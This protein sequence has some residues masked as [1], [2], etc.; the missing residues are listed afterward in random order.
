MKGFRNSL[1]LTGE[2]PLPPEVRISDRFRG[3]FTEINPPKEIN[4]STLHKPVPYKWQVLKILSLSNEATS[5]QIYNKMS[6]IDTHPDIQYVSVCM[7]L[8]LSKGLAVRTDNRRLR[9][10]TYTI[11]KNGR[12]ISRKYG[13][14]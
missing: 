8:F 7:S 11:T 12:R 9:P 6:S 2:D 1:T 14:N 3:R 5:R 13:G 10:Y 4:L